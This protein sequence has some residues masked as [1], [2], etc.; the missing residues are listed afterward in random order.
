MGRVTG[1]I[2]PCVGF[3]VRQCR[4]LCE[5]QGVTY[6]E[7][8]VLSRPMLCLAA[9]SSVGVLLMQISGWEKSARFTRSER[10]PIP[11][12]R[13]FQKTLDKIEEFWDFS[14]KR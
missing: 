7:P 6:T 10:F 13:S 8:C 1:D 11:W 12:S 9:P 3:Q 14:T 5:H 4:G 2:A